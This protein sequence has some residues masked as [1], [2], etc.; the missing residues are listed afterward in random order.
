MKIGALVIPFV[1]IVIF[2]NYKVDPGR[3]YF[4]S[5]EDSIELDAVKILNEGHGAKPIDNFDDRFLKREYLTQMK[6]GKN[7]VVLG[8]SRAALITTEMLRLER[9]DFF[10]AYV[11]GATLQDMIAL[12]GI[13][14]KNGTMPENLV[15]VVDPWI[16]N[17]N[18]SDDRFQHSIGD[19]YYYYLTERLGIDVDPS[20]AN[21][22]PL[23]RN[24]GN[25]G[26]FFTLPSDVILNLVSVTYFQASIQRVISGKYGEN[27][28]I[29]ATDEE[30]SE[31]GLLRYDGSF[32]YPL[33]F[34]EAAEEEVFNRILMAQSNVTG[35]EDYDLLHSENKELFVKWLNALSEDGVS[36]T[37]VMPPLND[38][39]YIH[40]MSFPRY[41]NFFAVEDMLFEIADSTDA[42]VVGTYNPYTYSYT[43]EQFYDAYHLKPQGISR[44]LEDMPDLNLKGVL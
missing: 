37:L 43:I 35:L 42:V 15:I 7:T 12:F 44:I 26:G 41:N 34:R 27:I 2:T 11:T 14:Y 28:T 16:L 18:V 1:F 17:D 25:E 21:I 32:C 9:G 10:N 38:S 40:L 29:S 33:D 13:M 6:E 39:L 36:V 20:I 5:R 22:R 8:S 30:Y 19:G 4:S 3:L 31:I 23:Y 24:D